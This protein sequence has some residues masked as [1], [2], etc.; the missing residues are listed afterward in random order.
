MTKSDNNTAVDV[1]HRLLVPLLRAAELCFGLGE[2][3][4]EGG[5]GVGRG[6]HHLPR[7]RR[8][9]GALFFTQ[10]HQPLHFLF[11]CRQCSLRLTHGRKPHK[12]R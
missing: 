9:S 4:N 2:V 3:F 8:N 6:H 11:A 10:L 5:V 12:N 7:R 1:T